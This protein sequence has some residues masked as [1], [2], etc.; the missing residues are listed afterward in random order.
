MSAA[1]WKIFF[2][3]MVPVSELRA[4]IP[5]GVV[6]GLNPFLTAV[7]AVAGNMIPVP[8]VVLF[9]RQIF[10]WARRRSPWLERR[11]TRFEEK[12]DRKAENV[13]K[14]ERLGLLLFVAVPL[15]GTGAWT[16][17]AIA[18]ILDLR[19]RSAA[20]SILGGLI[21]AACIMTSIS[22]GIVQL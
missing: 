17:A 14:Y 3:A 15:P 12:L 22:F 21:I 13:L 18:A 19:L 7:A 11:V 5:I 6:Q 16:G 10:D 20:L 9:I 8:F 4:A 1:Y 2:M